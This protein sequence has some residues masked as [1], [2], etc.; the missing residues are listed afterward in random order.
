MYTDG[1]GGS[2]SL[3]E[4]EREALMCAM[5]E[6]RQ[7]EEALAWLNAHAPPRPQ[8]EQ[9]LGASG[10]EEGSAGGADGAVFG[11]NSVSDYFSQFSQ[12]NRPQPRA[13]PPQQA[14][15]QP[16]ERERAELE[17]KIPLVTFAKLDHRAIPIVPVDFE[18]LIAGLG[19]LVRTAMPL[20]LAWAMTMHKAQG[21]SLD[22]MSCDLS[23]CFADG[24][25]YVALS[26]ATGYHALQLI[27]AP[28][29]IGKNL[30]TSE[31]VKSFYAHAHTSPP[32]LLPQA[33]AGETADGWAGTPERVPPA[34]QID[35]PVAV[36]GGW[37]A[38]ETQARDNT[39]ELH[40]R[41]TGGRFVPLKEIMR[42]SCGGEH[43]LPAEMEAAIASAGFV[44]CDACG[45]KNCVPCW[46]HHR[47]RRA[48]G[49]TAQRTAQQ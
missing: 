10:G 25:V 49:A 45:K 21:A 5:A 8:P 6:V 13:P 7:C 35:V 46:E 1:G 33:A 11:G 19:A 29:A 12:L 44:Q 24:Q 16:R 20:A 32:P 18:L 31:L 14:P 2:S 22:C 42:P 40:E 4:Q 15:Q 26:R 30:R 43:D 38:N 39:F 34:A 48:R 9:T 47:R 28:P 41:I 27:G 36:G 17:L 23:R 3:S 37:W